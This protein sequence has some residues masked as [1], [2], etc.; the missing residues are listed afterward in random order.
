MLDTLANIVTIYKKEGARSNCGNYRG[1]SML[2]VA[3][4]V[5]TKVLNKRFN[6][7]IAEIVLT[8]PQSGFRAGRSTTDMIFVCRQVIE[9][10]RE[11]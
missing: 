1:L 4:K 8:E 3:G 7:S 9:K 10:A 5:L 2:D 6:S 11:Q